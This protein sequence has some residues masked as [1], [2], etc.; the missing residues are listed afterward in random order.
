MTSSSNYDNFIV[1]YCLFLK[2]AMVNNLPSWQPVSENYSPVKIAILA[3]RWLQEALSILLLSEDS[4]LLVANTRSEDVLFSLPI[5]QL[6]DIIVIDA[7][8]RLNKAVEQI[9]RVKTKLNSANYLMLVDQT[10][11]YSPLT[12][13]GADALILK[14]SPPSIILEIIKQVADKRRIKIKEKNKL[15]TDSPPRKTDSEA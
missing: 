6:P 3:P 13:A 12:E 10:S 15:P 14:G 8:R 1:K 4:F 9:T 11:Q 5:P 7:D 2:T